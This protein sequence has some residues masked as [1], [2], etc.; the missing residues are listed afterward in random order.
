MI[1]IKTI[2][3]REILN[4]KGNPTV[5][6]TVHLSNDI[7]ATASCPSGTSVSSYEAVEVQVGRAVENVI[8]KISPALQDKD[9]TK[10]EDIDGTMIQLNGSANKR[11]LGV[12]AILPV[13][14]AVA[15][16]AALAEEMTL[17]SYISQLSHSEKSHIPI[18]IFNLINGG[19]HALH[20][21]DIQEFIVIPMNSPSFYQ[22]LQMGCTIRQALQK[23]LLMNNYSTLVGD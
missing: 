4:A 10:Q 2:T 20:S 1:S 3:A 13:S 9:I 12:N 23:M 6:A 17:F 18:P 16:A 5:E 11:I 15:K 14:L 19:K 21:F 8:K 22:S 7:S